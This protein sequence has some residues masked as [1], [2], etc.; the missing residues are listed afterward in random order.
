[1]PPKKASPEKKTLLGRPGNN[2]KIGIVGVPNVGKSSF[3]NTLSKTDLGKAANFPYATI[4]PEEARIP[5][6]DTRFDWLATTYRPAGRVPAFL[7]CIDIAG[8]TAGASTGAGL[9]NSFLSHVRSVD[10]IFQV[11]RAFDDAEVIH[12]EG[13]VDPLRDM[14]IISTELRLKDIEWVEKYLDSIKKSGRSLGSNSL[15]DRARK[16][17]IATVEKIYSVLTQDNKDVRK[18]DWVGKEIDVVNSLQLLTAKPVTYL[19]NLSERDYIRKKNKWLPKIKGW[20]DENNPGDPL[21][22]FSVAL[23]ERLMSLSSDEERAEE[24][25]KVGATSA[26]GKITTAGYASL[27]LIRYFTC[28]PQEVRAWTIRKG[29]KAPQA[30]GVIHSDFENK[31]VCGEIMSYE[32]LREHGSEAAVKAAGKLKQ[33]GKTYEMIDGDIAY[34]KSGA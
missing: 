26:L 13:D 14:D 15:A 7:T 30:A 24:E 9:G 1:M 11:V 12:V 16:E 18:H 23:E 21:I 32:D 29:T 3:F 22:P 25:K 31:F 10:G 17:E 20:I 27:E 34:W 33:Q 28:G 8:L 19:V 5:V 6:P 4:N 2:L